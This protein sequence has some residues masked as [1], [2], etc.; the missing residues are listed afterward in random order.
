MDAMP[1]FLGTANG[2]RCGFKNHLILAQIYQLACPKPK[3]VPVRRKDH[4]RI[5]KAT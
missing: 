1:T 3:S 2:Q 5:P 4:G